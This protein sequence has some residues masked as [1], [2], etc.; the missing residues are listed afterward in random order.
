MSTNTQL[1]RIQDGQWFKVIRNASIQP[2]MMSDSTTF[3]LFFPP[4]TSPY[5][6]YLCSMMS[7]PGSVSTRELETVLTLMVSWR[8]G[9]KDF[10]CLVPHERPGVTL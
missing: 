10:S 3:F 9:D 6:L 4:Q 8:L 2:M 7:V 1:G 5:K